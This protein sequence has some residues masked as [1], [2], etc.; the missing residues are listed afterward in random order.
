MLPSPS[1]ISQEYISVISCHLKRITLATAMWVRDTILSIY[2][3]QSLC[4]SC[5]VSWYSHS[6][7]DPSSTSCSDSPCPNDS[8]DVSIAWTSS[9]FLTGSGW[10]WCFSHSHCLWA[11]TGAEITQSKMNDHPREKCPISGIRLFF[12][13]CAVFVISSFN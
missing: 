5:F 9:L 10:C 11:I 12:F 4:L 2:N 13:V 7:I 6:C 8:R 1:T 3:P